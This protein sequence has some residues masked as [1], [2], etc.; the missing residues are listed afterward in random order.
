MSTPA[1]LKVKEIFLNCKSADKYWDWPSKYLETPFK[2]N[3]K[4]SFV[5]WCE[6]SRYLGN[7]S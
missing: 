6:R 5:F 4:G 1:F 2:L 3:N 7:A